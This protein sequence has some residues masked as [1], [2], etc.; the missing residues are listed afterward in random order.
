[1]YVVPTISAQEFKVEPVCYEIQHI[2]KDLNP[3][4]S[5]EAFTKAID[6]IKYAKIPTDQK[7][8]NIEELKINIKN[9][10]KIPQFAE[11]ITNLP[12]LKI[13]E[14]HPELEGFSKKLGVKFTEDKGRYAVASEIIEPGQSWN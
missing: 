1:M 7:K 2:K 6:L 8:N 4:E 5:V 9:A 10:D 14:E 12:S 13:V 3:S 11:E